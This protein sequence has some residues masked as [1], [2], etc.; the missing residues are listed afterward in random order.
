MTALVSEAANAFAFGPFLLIPE[1]QQLLRHQE[2]LRVGGRALDLLTALVQRPGEVVSKRDLIARVWPGL[3]VE[4]GNLKVNISAL[5]RL[6][7]DGGDP[8]GYIETVVG[9][10]YRFNGAV[11]FVACRATPPRAPSPAR[12]DNLPSLDRPLRGRDDTIASVLRDL[13]DSRLVSIV[14]AGGIGKTTVAAAVARQGA[15]T[16]ERGARWVDLAALED[17]ALV[18]GA[19]ADALRDSADPAPRARLRTGPGWDHG[20]LLVLDN[21]EHLIAAVAACA[22]QLLATTRQVKLLATS[23]EPLSIRGELV[24]R[25]PGLALPPEPSTWLAAQPPAAAQALS[26]A[27]PL[28]AAQALS[29]PAVQLL[30]DRAL[31]ASDGF[32]LDDT[33]AADV[34]EICRRLDGHALAIERVARRLGTLGVAGTLDHLSRRFHMLDGHHEGPARHRTLTATVAASHDL[35][36]A[37]EQALL[38]RL[39]VFDGPFRL[40]DAREIGGGADMA[41]ALV[42]D[43]IGQLVAKSLLVAEARDGEMQYRLTQLT[44]AFAME[45]LIAQGEL[46]DVRHRLAVLLPSV[47]RPSSKDAAT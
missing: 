44:R 25:L 33:N 42:V 40:A 37:G 2:P 22:D 27:Q 32:R 31:A 8:S 23:R 9:H 24:R 20:V 47:P 13:E 10:G 3:V 15:A 7:E 41:G 30:V 38:R 35:L 45:Q 21:C 14:G 4:E 28:T 16:F 17:P 36:C 6:L 18:P 1:R 43:H 26:A 5:R 46:D 12:I 29:W 19:I 39:A 11:R 34:V